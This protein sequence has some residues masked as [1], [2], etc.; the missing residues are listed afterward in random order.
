MGLPQV[1][2]CVVEVKAVDKARDPNGIRC[3][4]G[5]QKNG[6]PSRSPGQ[7]PERTSQRDYRCKNSAPSWLINQHETNKPLLLS[8]ALRVAIVE[9]QIK[10]LSQNGFVKR[11]KSHSPNLGLPLPSRG[12]RLAAKVEVGEATLTPRLGGHQRR[13]RGAFNRPETVRC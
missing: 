10:L 11:P 3:Q 2:D 5:P 9:H 6:T 12:R 1:V 13:L 8:G 7:A 4:K